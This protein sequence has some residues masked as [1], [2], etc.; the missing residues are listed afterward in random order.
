MNLNENVNN[1]EFVTNSSEDEGFKELESNISIQI[2]Q[3]TLNL[4]GSSPYLLEKARLILEDHFSELSFIAASHRRSPYPS[5]RRTHFTRKDLER[6]NEA[7]QLNQVPSKI[8]YS[9]DQLLAFAEGT[10]TKDWTEICSRFP[11]IAREK[12]SLEVPLKK[13]V[14]TMIKFQAIEPPRITYKSEMLLYLARNRQSLSPPQNWKKIEER[15]PEIV[16][17]NTVQFQEVEVF[18][19]DPLNCQ[20][21]IESICPIMF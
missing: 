1:E 17:K 11:S 19:R 21:Y 13:N 9:R 5:G 6:C 18:N 4:S 10:L 12:K 3:E 16:Y 7:F 14:I 8:V 20:D 2:C 15:F